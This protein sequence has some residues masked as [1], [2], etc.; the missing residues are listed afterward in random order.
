MTDGGRPEAGTTSPPP[1]DRVAALGVD[2][3][4][5]DQAIGGWRGLIDS[6]VPASLFVIVYMLNGQ[7]LRSAVVAAVGSAI[8]IGLFRVARREP[9]QQVASGFFGVAISAF[10]A[11]RTGRAEDYFLVGL[12]INVGY[13]AAYLVSILVRWPLIG[14]VVGYLRNDPTGWRDDPAQYRAHAT[15]SWVWVAM[16]AIRLVTQ[17]PMYVLGAVGALGVAKLVMGWPMFL[18]AAYLTYRIIHPVLSRPAAEPQPD[19]IVG[20]SAL[21][22]GASA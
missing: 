2:R 6:G 21:E 13:M 17:V 16:F 14:L 7:V 22:P 1:H 19:P 18:L 5:L 20:S 3:A 15:A 4:M 9:L 10:V 12:L 8:A 11:T